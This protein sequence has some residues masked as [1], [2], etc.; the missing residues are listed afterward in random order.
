MDELEPTMARKVGQGE[1]DQD[2]D[3]PA[4]RGGQCHGMAESRCECTC[5]LSTPHPLLD[6]LQ[7]WFM[8]VLTLHH[9]WR[10]FGV[11]LRGLESNT[12]RGR[13]MMAN[14]G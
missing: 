12:T 3:F 4:S 6:L 9:S 7:A 10:W 13:G 11:P 5:R 1:M 2:R 8:L 14:S